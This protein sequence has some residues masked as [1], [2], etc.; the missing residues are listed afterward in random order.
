M[1]VIVDTSVW[2]LALGRSAVQKNKYVEELG[3]LIKE[4][5]V[6]LLGRIRQE[7]LRQHLRAFRD[8]E[9]GREDYEMASAYFNKARINGIRGSNTDFSI[10]AISTRLIVPIFSTDKDFLNFQS[11]LPIELHTVRP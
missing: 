6:L 3:E 9:I 10:C 1:K 4:A 2:S 8:L 11:I 5:R 7:V